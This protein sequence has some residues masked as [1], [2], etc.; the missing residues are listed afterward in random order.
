MGL[1][2]A[3]GPLCCTKEVCFSLFL[4]YVQADRPSDK[5]SAEETPSLSDY[6]TDPAMSFQEEGFYTSR[7]T[8]LS[9]TS[10][11]PNSEPPGTAVVG[12]SVSGHSV[13][14]TGSRQLWGCDSCA[15]SVCSE[16][17]GFWGFK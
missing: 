6:A 7:L 11:G 1:S 5:T 17:A 13:V 8:E 16:R 4:S 10:C 15:A 12:F 2:A 9:A 14:R 3:V